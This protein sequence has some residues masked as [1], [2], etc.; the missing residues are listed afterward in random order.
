MGTP[1]ATPT[2]TNTSTPT[3]TPTATATHTETPQPT[4]LSTP[5]PAPTTLLK[6]GVNVGQDE[7]NAAMSKWNALAVE[8]YEMVVRVDSVAPFAGTWTLLVSPDSIETISYS[9]DTL[10]PTTPPALMFGEALRFLSVEG[11]FAS[12]QQRLTDGDF[13]QE[14]E[15]RVDYYVAFDPVFGYPTSVEI[16]TKPGVRSTTLGSLTTIQRITIVKRG[17]LVV[18]T[19][20]PTSIPTS[21]APPTVPVPTPAPSLPPPQPTAAPS[22]SLPLPTPQPTAP[23]T[24]TAAGDTA[25]PT[26][27]PLP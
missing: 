3:E 6:P 11:Q 16:K 5:A 23:P 2:P 15:S 22:P 25:T 20:V 7:L 13:G 24:L 14:L 17:T 27:V 19:L 8:R 12:V 9:R 18:P 4:V 26:L 21:N 10:T 1:T